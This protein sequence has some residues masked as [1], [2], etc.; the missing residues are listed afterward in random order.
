MGII[1][2]LAQG[3]NALG[4]KVSEIQQQQLL[5]YLQLLV[6]WNQAF[7]LTAVRD[8]K[9][10]VT[11]HLLD[12]LAILP[13]LQGERVLDVGSGAGL[14]GIPLAITDPTRQYVLLDSNGKKVR[15]LQQAIVSLQLKHVTA[16]Q[17]RAEQF[18]SEESFDSILAR[19][20]GEIGEIIELTKHLISPQGQWILMKGR[21]PEAELQNIKHPAKIVPLVI[22]GLTEARHVVIVSAVQQR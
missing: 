5:A 4:L 20:V 13:Y 19:A 6:K 11:K 2:E 8:P 9:E 17:A 22:P 7:N 21:E 1:I 14:P 12:S 18:Q 3:I 10:M 16:V 15:F